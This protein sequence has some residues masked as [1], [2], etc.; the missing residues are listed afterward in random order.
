MSP[1]PSPYTLIILRSHVEVSLHPPIGESAWTDIEKLGG[2]VVGEIKQRKQVRCLIDLTGLDYMA[3][4]LV[5]LLVRLWKEIQAAKGEM[6]IVASHP[7]VRET[8]TL[9]GLD[10]IWEIHGT[11]DAGCRSLGVPPPTAREASSQSNSKR[12]N[13]WIIGAILFVIAA[14]GISLFVLN[15]Q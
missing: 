7:V 5:A 9:A 6:V 10:K 14:I 12:K 15:Q 2:E 4:S 1:P 13:R 3:S 8:L 11:L